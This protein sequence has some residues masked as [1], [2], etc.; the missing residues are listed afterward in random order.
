MHVI[1]T[2]NTERKMIYAILIFIID[3]NSDW[4]DGESNIPPTAAP[5]SPYS[6]NVDCKMRIIATT[7]T[8]CTITLTERLKL[9]EQTQEL[10]S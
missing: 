5:S 10:Q 1:I 3:S 4:S 9:K 6:V 7:N 2:K 8:H